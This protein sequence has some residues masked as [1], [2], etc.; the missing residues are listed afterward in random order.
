MWAAVTR[1]AKTGT[2]KLSGEALS[3]W[4]VRAPRFPLT[5]YQK[6]AEI[7]SKFVSAG[8]ISQKQAQRR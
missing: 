2:G 1:R 3:G 4:R 5:Y 7:G 8:G 6:F